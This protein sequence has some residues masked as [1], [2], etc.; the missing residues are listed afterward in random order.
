[1]ITYTYKC[2][3]CGKEFDKVQRITD[4]PVKKCPFCGEEALVM[5]ISGG[6]GF[7]FRGSTDWASNKRYEEFNQT[8]CSQGRSCENPKRCCER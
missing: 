2:K 4:S 6:S 8:C 5:I 7:I 3:N 1:M